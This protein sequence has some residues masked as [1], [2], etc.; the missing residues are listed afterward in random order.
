M[1]TNIDNAKSASTETFVTALVFNAAVFA[2]EIVLFTFLRPRF[3]AIY[4]P[5]TYV[6]PKAKRVQ[7][8]SS[9][10]IAWPVA[11]FRSNFVDIIKAN[12]LDAYFFVRFLRMMAI[13][14]LPI[15]VISWA[16]LMPL[17]S[18]GSHV[19]PN[20]GLDNFGFG[21]I[22]NTLQV[23]YAAHI[24]LL[25]VFTAWMCWN[26]KKEMAHFIVTRQKYLMDPVHA[27]T[28]Q[29]TT[30]LVT[31]I[32]AKYLNR[33]ALLKVFGGLPG[34]VKNIWINKSVPNPPF[35]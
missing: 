26:I 27:K 22:Q 34:G 20:K 31:G 30:L 1:S 15:W 25:Y 3:P 23:R 29:A 8:L 4:Q 17:T 5:R 2:I 32:P 7:P 28:A 6:P 16:V 33:E 12:G 21:N 9:S 13:V 14:F 24:V 10:L 19:D 35:K 11:V 18:V